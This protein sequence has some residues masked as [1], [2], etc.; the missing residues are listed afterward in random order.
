MTD[1]SKNAY[2]P[3]TVSSPGST[4]AG[5]LE[6]QNI[7]QNEL[8]VRM[9]V[10]PKFVN[11]LVGGKVS[12]SPGVALLLERTLGVPADFWLARDAQYQAF[13]ARSE[14]YSE[15]EAQSEWLQELPLKEMIRFDW[16]RKCTSPAAQV[17][18]C[19][20]Y[21]GVASASAWREQYVKRV[22]AS[23][24][25]RISEQ[26]T[27]A[28]GAIAAWLRQGELEA[29]QVK[30]H[31]FDREL[32]IQVLDEVRTLTLES[33]PEIFIPALKELLAHC[34]VAVVLIPAPKG[35]PASGA[36]R[37]IAPQKALVQLSLRYKTND[38]LW[39][40]FFHECAH[41]LLHGKKMLFLEGANMSG[42]EEDEANLYASQ[43]LIPQDEFDAFKRCTP[44]RENIINF[45][46]RIGI[47]P[48]IVLG[49][50]QK[51]DLIAW[52][53]FYDLKIRYRWKEA[54]DSD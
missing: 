14:A 52:S 16:I 4:L 26:V 5:L 3:E 42:S 27:H 8:A 17:A 28:A 48:G 40:T 53:K 29:S 47:A 41:L 30:C 6:E 24:A 11:E 51:E 12:I 37:W 22:Q 32:L 39:F 54:D 44:T 9:D 35:C 33:K 36:V 2:Q 18:E 19:L 10:T 25:W 23:T 13:K 15:L 43:R 34:G 46:K 1:V 50:M 31:P 21:F 20:Q 45:A 49:R 38:H 7:R